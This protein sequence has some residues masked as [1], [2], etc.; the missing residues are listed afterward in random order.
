[1]IIKSSAKLNINNKIKKKS[2]TKINKTKKHH[3]VQGVEFA[4]DVV[5]TDE[6]NKWF[7]GSEVRWRLFG[8]HP[9][10]TVELAERSAFVSSRF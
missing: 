2:T 10:V 3:S 6:R 5:K 9:I 4:W 1:M 8:V 7:N